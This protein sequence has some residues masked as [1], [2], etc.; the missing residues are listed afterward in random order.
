M[1]NQDSETLVAAACARFVTE[2]EIKPPYL[3]PHEPS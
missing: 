1:S 2:H 3:N